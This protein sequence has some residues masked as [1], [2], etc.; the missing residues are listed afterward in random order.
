[1]QL[2]PSSAAKKLTGRRKNPRA[3]SDGGGRQLQAFRGV[4][5]RTRSAL[6]TALAD[7]WKEYRAALIEVPLEPGDLSP[8][9]R[10]FVDAFRARLA[11]SSQGPANGRTRLMA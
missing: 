7:A 1:M 8:V 2:R 4:A 5:V 6:R 11:A 3:N 9:L 10:R